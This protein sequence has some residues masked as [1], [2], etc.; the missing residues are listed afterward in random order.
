MQ[1][2]SHALSG[3][4]AWLAIGSTSS[5]ALGIY[6]A[7]PAVTL[8]G[9]II[10]AG[11]ALLPD[12]DHPSGTI[13]WSLPS[14][15]AVGVTLIPSPTKAL[16]TGVEAISGGHRHATHSLIGIAAFTGLAWLSTFVAFEYHGRSIALASAVYAIL[17]IAFAVKA[18]GIARSSARHS[19]RRAGVIGTVVSG[20]LGSWVGPWVIAL[21][22]AGYVTWELEYRW[23]W[24][25][26]A[27]LVGALLHNLGDSLTV[28][29]VPWL[30]PLNPKPPKGLAGGFVGVLWQRNGYFRVPVLGHT[31]SI[32]EKV[33][34]T[35]LALYTIYL[36]MYESVRVFTIPDMLF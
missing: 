15:E 11:A 20:I 12:I 1:G 14:V 17:L 18:L 3:S 31:E 19:R 29:G 13:A 28:E 9:A 33:F 26:L 8:A 34:A 21:G 10:C 25:P 32:R 24:L 22:T 6:D 30:W 23:T 27:V 2:Y 36:L 35:A 16:C 7:P 5:A 4:A